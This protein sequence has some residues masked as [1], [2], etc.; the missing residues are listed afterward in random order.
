MASNIHPVICYDRAHDAI[1]WLCRA[2]GFSRGAVHE[3]NGRVAHAEVHRGEAT[4]GLSSTRVP[5]PANVWTTTREGIYVSVENAD[6]LHERARSA[7]ADIVM[8]LTDATYGSRDF[9]V[10]DPDGHLWGF[11]TYAMGEAPERPL[12]YPG[13]RY[14]SAVEAVAFLAG[15]FGLS[16]GVTLEEGGRIVAG[17][18]WS[19]AGV[20]LVVDGASPGDRWAGR[21][22][23]TYMHV[24]DPAAHHA[25][26][27]AA[28]AHIL[29]P[30]AATPYGAITYVAQDPEGLLWSFTTHQPARPAA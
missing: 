20:V 23:C 26:A 9:S 10:R 13:L 27:V 15:A 5:D 16:Q 4:I 1:D 22:Q 3:D 6:A 12:V 24:T 14:G 28:G 19:D 21:R 2:F 18:I 29:S 30:P 17:E 7:G 8:P 25:T 11:G